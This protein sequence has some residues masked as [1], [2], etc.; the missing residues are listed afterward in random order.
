MMLFCD[1]NCTIFHTTKRLDVIAIISNI[2]NTQWSIN[3]IDKNNKLSLSR[4]E[5]LK[6]EWNA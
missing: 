5:K 1:I 2:G 6:M 3:K 4:T